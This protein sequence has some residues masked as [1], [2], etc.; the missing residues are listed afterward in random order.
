MCVCQGPPLINYHRLTS[1]RGRGCI[2]VFDRQVKSTLND[3]DPYV[4]VSSSQQMQPQI[5]SPTHF[6]YKL[7]FIISPFCDS[8]RLF[9]YFL[10][11]CNPI[12]I[13]SSLKSLTTLRNI[14]NVKMNYHVL[15]KFFY[16]FSIY[17]YIIIHF[18]IH[19]MY[20]IYYFI[21]LKVSFQSKGDPKFSSFCSS[22]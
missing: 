15:F 5:F 13:S 17:I 11:F 10:T 16:L 7:R 22:I 9:P 19:I 20:F 6:Q 21:H 2:T 4:I 1:E 18:I 8:S 14:I 12:S 3:Y